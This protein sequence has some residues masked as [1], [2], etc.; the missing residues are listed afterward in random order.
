M[1]C[2]A[3]LQGIFLTQESNLGLPHCRRNLYHLSHQGNLPYHIYF[4]YKG[5]TQNC[6]YAMIIMCKIDIYKNKGLKRT[7]MKTVMPVWWICGG[8]YEN[9][10]KGVQWKPLLVMKTWREGVASAVGKAQTVWVYIPRK[11]KALAFHG[12]EANLVVSRTQVK[13]YCNWGKGKGWNS[14]PYIL[15]RVGR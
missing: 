15:G 10:W 3:L 7:K 2:H 8:A 1:G 12:K 6:T 11:E 5:N 4:W 14:K 13:I 9:D